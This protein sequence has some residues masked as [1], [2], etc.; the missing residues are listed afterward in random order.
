[1]ISLYEK[2]SII[3]EVPHLF[4]PALL[5]VLE[6]KNNTKKWGYK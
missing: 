4:A 2:S 1:M 6:Q 3:T 5:L